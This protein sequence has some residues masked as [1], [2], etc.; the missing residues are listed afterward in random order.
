MA[1]V[2]F[3]QGHLKI[4][5]DN[6][7]DIV[8]NEIKSVQFDSI[9][10]EPSLVPSTKLEKRKSKNVLSSK[11]DFE[12]RDSLILENLAKDDVNFYVKLM[13][14]KFLSIPSFYSPDLLLNKP[15]VNLKTNS[16]VVNQTNS[17]FSISLGAGVNRSIGIYD[18]KGAP[19]YAYN[20]RKHE[21]QA[22]WNSSFFLELN[23]K[24]NKRIL[25][26]SGIH[27][28]QYGFRNEYKPYLLKDYIEETQVEKTTKLYIYN[29]ISRRALLEG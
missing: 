9:R 19:S 2:Q 29:P 23:Y 13:P 20:R 10:M 26:S 21:E 4:G 12:K 15:M 11:I 5:N 6:N 1:M 7:F 18:H 27:L 28:V 22:A 17:K 3:F 25:L 16:K 24:L 14:L 8:R